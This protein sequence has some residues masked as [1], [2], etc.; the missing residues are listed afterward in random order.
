VKAGSVW[1]GLTARG[2]P[3][4]RKDLTEMAAQRRTYVIRFAY[5]FVLFVTACTLFYANIG[6]SAGAGQTLGRGAAHFG[7]LMIFQLAALYLIVPILTAG[8]VTA[9]K[10]RETL[11]LLLLTTLTPRQIVMQKFASRM[12]PILSF[13]FLSFP[14]LAITYTFGGVT[15]Q[16]LVLGIFVLLAAALELGAFAIM[17]STYFRTTV[18]ALIATYVGCPLITATCPGSCLFL[19][20]PPNGETVSLVSIAL[21]STGTSAFVV[22]GCL[23]MAESILVSRA[24]V[25][26]RSPLLQFFRWLDRQYE[27]MNVVTGG[28]VLVR[29]RD[30]LPR[31]APVRWRE[32]QKKSLGTVRYL[33]RV[34][35]LLECPILFAIQWIRGN[36]TSLTDDGTMSGLLSL[37]WIAAAILIG[38]YSASVIS[39][40][41]S[42]QTLGILAAS[43]LSTG[44]ILKEKLGGV[45]RLMWV[46]LVPFV[47]IFVFEQWWYAR[48]D[49]DYLILSAL[50]VGVYLPTVEWLGL[51]IGLRMQKQ[52][53]AIIVTL[54]IAT[55]WIGGLAVLPELLRYFQIAPGLIDR[56]AACLSPA[57]MIWAVQRS[58]PHY[59]GVADLPS[60]WETSRVATVVHFAFYAGCYGLF[61]WNCVWNADRHLG[62]IHQP[63]KRSDM[64]KA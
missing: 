9:E 17:C 25:P 52:L 63:L 53:S 2:L 48:R 35:V 1:R 36:S 4:L 45:H 42:R 16:E 14:L 26:Y 47:T 38:V 10:E 43:P 57:D 59:R 61:R 60:P 27:Q 21:V 37:V 12:T 22:A 28:I 7:N 55:V 41:R 24:F 39:E 64:L 44:Q 54:V 34:L 56:I 29:D 20:R 40:E 8:A 30:H 58:A 51:S 19:M 33:F 31:R 23:S 32:T 3:I 49:Y 46:L 62:R 13:V 18:E 11:S 50:T 15:I 6:V 5:A